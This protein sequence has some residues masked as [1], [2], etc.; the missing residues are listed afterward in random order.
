MCLRMIYRDNPISRWVIK[1]AITIIILC[2]HGAL[3]LASPAGEIIKSSSIPSDTWRDTSFMSV[4]SSDISQ[5]SHSPDGSHSGNLISDSH[6]NCWPRKCQR[7]DSIHRVKVDE[8]PPTKKRLLSPGQPIEFESGNPTVNS[9]EP[10]PM[11][12]KPEEEE[13]LGKVTFPKFKSIPLQP[14]RP[15]LF[16]LHHKPARFR[17]PSFRINFPF[18]RSI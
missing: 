12:F 6:P 8:E 15:L 11:S 7:L 10:P 2:D 18:F 3:R 4:A 13:N 16:F 14:P 9:V 17:F 1:I 5:Q